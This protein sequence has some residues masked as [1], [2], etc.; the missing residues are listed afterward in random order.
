MTLESA[1]LL[2]PKLADPVF[3]FFFLELPL[4]IGQFLLG[5]LQLAIHLSLLGSLLQSLLRVLYLSFL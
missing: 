5:L 4:Q 3:L 2:Y 1:E